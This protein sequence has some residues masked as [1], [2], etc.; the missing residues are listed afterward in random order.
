MLQ[1]AAARYEQVK[2]TTTSKG[3]LLLALYRGLFRF[4]N[5]AR[6]CFEQGKSA[7]GREL[8][9]KAH[10][11]ITELQIALDPDQSPGLCGNLYGVYDFSLVTL[12]EASLRADASKVEE[13]LQVLTPLKEA[14]EKAVP[15]AARQGICHR[16]E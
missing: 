7:Q 11:V 10:A 13:V 16:A 5:G 6:A 4:L 8:I 3:E 12:R 14:W 9:S 15:E 2:V 1:N